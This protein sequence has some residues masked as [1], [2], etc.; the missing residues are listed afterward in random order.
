MFNRK[1]TFANKKFLPSFWV[2]S[3]LGGLPV[4]CSC[5]LSPGQHSADTVNLICSADKAEALVYICSY[6]N[7]WT[8]KH[9]FGKTASEPFFFCSVRFRI[10]GFSQ[11][12]GITNTASTRN[13]AKIFPMDGSLFSWGAALY[14]KVTQNAHA[15]GN[16]TICS[17]FP[18]HHLS[19]DSYESSVNCS[20]QTD[21]V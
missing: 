9:S 4:L 2:K 8:C 18:V 21:T 12:C 20:N 15:M 7:T 11:P 16:S 1:V 3:F 10:G 6:R 17:F 19:L 5:A 13:L 14:A